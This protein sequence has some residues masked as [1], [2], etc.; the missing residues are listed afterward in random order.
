MGTLFEVF[1]AFIH[2]FEI[3]DGD[4]MYSRNALFKSKPLWLKLVICLNF[5]NRTKYVKNK[6]HCKLEQR[7]CSDCAALVK[8]AAGNSKD[9]SNLLEKQARLVQFA[10]GAS[11]ISQECLQV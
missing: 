6:I 11:E 9:L 10:A 3:R 2:L 4:E 8:L 7:K 5:G 1:T